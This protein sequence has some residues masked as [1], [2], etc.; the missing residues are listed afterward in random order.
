MVILQVTGGENFR[1]GPARVRTAGE[2]IL[3]RQTDSKIG[4]DTGYITFDVWLS[5]PGITYQLEMNIEAQALKVVTP[6]F[7]DLSPGGDHCL[8][9]EI[10]VWI[11]PNASFENILVEATSLSIRFMDDIDVHVSQD[12]KF[13]TH[14]GDVSFPSGNLSSVEISKPSGMPPGFSSRRIAVGTSS[15]D[16]TGTIFLYDLVS[17]KTDSGDIDITILPQPA[18]HDGSSNVAQITLGAASGDIRCRFPVYNAAKIP[19]RDYRTSVQTHSGDIRGYYVIGTEAIF[20]V[21]SGDIEIIALPTTFESSTFKT[22]TNSGSTHVIVLEPLSRHRTSSPLPSDS[23]DIGND[24][25][26][27]IHPPQVVPVDPDVLVAQSPIPERHLR[28]LKSYHVCSSGDQKIHY[29]TA[30]DGEITA[31]NITG[32]IRV[33]GD[34]VRIIRD[35]KKNWAYHEV[36]AR[37]G[38]G[39]EHASNLNVHG[40]SGSLDVWLG[41]DCL[42]SDW[43]KMD[44][45]DE[46]SLYRE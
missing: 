16:I 2:I 44:A 21:I 19:D 38:S 18:P 35:S 46:V 10:T 22:E 33:G 25:P 39:A 24:D 17:I 42:S 29:P 14:S 36:V 9:M 28:R 6:N 41:E 37:K 12:S 4:Q 31:V 45:I 15:G 8:S 7:A 27:L 1:G 3:R 13:E 23:I 30:W 43:C 26:Y 34:G 32:N 5:E 20:K 11:P 40:V